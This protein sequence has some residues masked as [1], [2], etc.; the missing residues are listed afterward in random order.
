MDMFTS[1]AARLTHSSPVAL[2]PSLAT[3][4]LFSEPA[5][6]LLGNCFN[7]NRM[8]VLVTQVPTARLGAWC[9]HYFCKSFG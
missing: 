1:Q 8:L 9:G 6:I 5:L 2:R 7:A 4:L 3:G